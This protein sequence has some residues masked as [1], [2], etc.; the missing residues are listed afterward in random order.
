MADEEGN[1]LG[2]QAHDRFVCAGDRPVQLGTPVPHPGDEENSHETVGGFPTVH[3]L[4]THPHWVFR[5]DRRDFVQRA[6][7]CASDWACLGIDGARVLFAGRCFPV[8]EIV[9]N[10]SGGLCPRQVVSRRVEDV[11]SDADH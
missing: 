8:R 2:L 4:L 7:H 5:Q 3:G 9:D 6:D 1:K 11:G 10:F